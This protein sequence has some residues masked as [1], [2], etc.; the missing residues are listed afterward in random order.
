M[1]RSR[2]NEE[3]LL[4]DVGI[5]LTLARDAAGK[6]RPGDVIEQVEFVTVETIADIRAITDEA[7]GPLRFQLNRSGQYVMQSIRS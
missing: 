2:R 1:Q 4:G 7:D 5:G 3:D 6:V